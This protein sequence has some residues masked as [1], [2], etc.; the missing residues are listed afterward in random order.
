MQG[1]HTGREPNTLEARSEAGVKEY[2]TKIKADF[3]LGVCILW[4]KRV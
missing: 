4:G 2:F 3:Y 1:K